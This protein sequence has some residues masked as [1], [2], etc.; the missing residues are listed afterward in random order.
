MNQQPQGSSSILRCPVQGHECL[1]PCRCSCR[2]Y[3]MYIAR[4]LIYDRNRLYNVM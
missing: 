3:Y 2:L 4:A 1:C